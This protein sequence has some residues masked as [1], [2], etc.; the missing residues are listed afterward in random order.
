MIAK[1]LKYL[2]NIF[3]NWQHVRPFAICALLALPLTAFAEDLSLAQREQI[4][5]AVNISESDWRNMTSGR[6]VIYHQ[7]GMEY[8]REYYPSSGN[9]TYFRAAN[10][11]C[12]E[13]EWS[14][15]DKIFCFDWGRDLPSCFFHKRVGDAIFIVGSTG[16][17]I[18][19]VTEII[20]APFQCAPELL[21]SLDVPRLIN[22]KL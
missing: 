3:A 13:G 21:S 7:D 18:Q 5:N 8:G 15:E 17:D 11:T 6:T 20:D 2:L 14:Y 12:L 4:I 9:R 10:G 19:Q 22:G 16:G 1:P